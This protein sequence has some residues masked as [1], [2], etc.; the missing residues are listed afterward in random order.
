MCGGTGAGFVLKHGLFATL[1]LLSSLEQVLGEIFILY[2]VIIIIFIVITIIIKS[3]TFSV[4]LHIDALTS[5]LCDREN[6]DLVG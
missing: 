3:I 5:L 6:Y 2:F 1:T 4:P